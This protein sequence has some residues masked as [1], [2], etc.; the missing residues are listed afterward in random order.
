MTLEELLD[1]LRN[2]ILHDRS[3]RISGTSDYLWTDTTL[4][5]YINEAQ[6]RFARLGLILRDAVTAEVTEITLVADQTEYVLHSSVIAVVSAKLVGDVVDLKRAGHSAFGVVPVVN[7]ALFDPSQ[8]SHLSPGKPLAY[9][10]DEGVAADADDALV[11]VTLRVYP[12]PSATYAGQKIKL[13]VVRLPINK[14][15]HKHDTPEI[16]ED[17]HLEML[18]WAAYLALR[19]VDHDAGNPGRAHE[20]RRMFEDHVVAAR[21]N[22]MRKMFAPIPWGF[23]QNGYSWE[24]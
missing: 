7:E 14:L 9:G 22:A 23:G 19:I 18:D 12:A 16:P 11:N 21:R 15:E 2:N 3:D 1:E 8:F 17:H 13:R 5:R 6:R 10:T 20:F 24:R 4:T